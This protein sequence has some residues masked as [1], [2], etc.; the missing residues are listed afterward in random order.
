MRAIRKH[1]SLPVI[2]GLK[3]SKRI[4][5]LF[6]FLSYLSFYFVLREIFLILVLFVLGLIQFLLINKKEY[7]EEYVFMVYF[8]SIIVLV[9]YL[10]KFF[11]IDLI[12][13]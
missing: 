13:N 2:F 3:K 6:F 9:I 10:T 1:A 4:I 7:H 11:D 5:D 12:F 8:L